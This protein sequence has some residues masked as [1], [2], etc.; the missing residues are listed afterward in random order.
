MGQAIDVTVTRQSEEIRF[1]Y[2]RD[3]AGQRSLDSPLGALDSERERISFVLLRDAVNFGSGYHPWLAKDAG[4]SGARTIGARLLAAVRRDGLPSAEALSEITAA[5]CAELLGQPATGRPGE[6]MGM[7]AAAW[8]GLGRAL[9]ERY[10]GDYLALVEESGDS[11]VVLAGLLASV[12][13]WNDISLYDGTEVPFLKRAQLAAL[14]VHRARE[15]SGRLGLDDLAGL[16]IFADNLIPH[17]LKLDGLLAFSAGLDERIE[18]GELLGHDSA[19]E[20]E[21]RAGAVHV[22]ELIA[23]AAARAGAPVAPVEL[24]SALWSRGQ[25]PR[26]KARPRHRSLTYAY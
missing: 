5:R 3:L 25:Q 17:V 19:P 14:G 24:A 20:V 18:A 23:A 12:P 6:L 1:L 7:F 11:A 16:T 4:M 10:D 2:G 26:Y 9:T 22:C 8:N 21:I 15:L 13:Y